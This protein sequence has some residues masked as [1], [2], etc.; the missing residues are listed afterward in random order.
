MDM[1]A[2]G[3]MEADTRREDLGR[4]ATAWLV[5]LDDEPDNDAL[6]VRFID[7]LAT[8][9]AHIEAWEETARV[10]A[11]M[12]AAGASSPSPAVRVLKAPARSRK[13][14]SARRLATLAIAACFAWLMIP[15]LSIYLRSDAI[16]RA[17]E[18]RVMKLAD[19]S[20]VHL[21]PTSAIAFD[22]DGKRRTLTLLR[23]EAWFDVAHDKTRPFT[24]IVGD[25]T[26]TVLGTAFSVRR[27]SVG[28]DVAVEQ[29]HV[30]VTGPSGG[31]ST[32]VELVAGQ[33]LSLG[34]GQASR[35][36][37]RTDRVASWRQGVAI[38]D[39][40]PISDVIAHIRPW[41]NGYIVTRGAGLNGR[42]V[43]GVYNLRDPDRALVALTRAHKVTVLQ[44]SPWIRVV[45]VG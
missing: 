30:A 13:M 45:T 22:D 4:Q 40:Q 26:V 37:I 9:P 39:D 28:V 43:S 38:V 1:G 33:A 34:Q 27:K 24:V 15:N 7:W 21:A 20:T 18:L 25:S 10:S 8:S 12:S 6:R 23:G 19:G 11:L 41:Y 17:G 42:H 31:R 44:V 3:G 16:T 35:T 14:S 5:H 29:G 32:R 36:M 2:K